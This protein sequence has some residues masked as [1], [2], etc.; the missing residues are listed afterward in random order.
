MAWA[1]LWVL[2]CR[3]EGSLKCP[4]L[5]ALPSANRTPAS[6]D[7]RG[8]AMWLPLATRRAQICLGLSCELG[9]FSHCSLGLCKDVLS[10]SVTAARLWISRGESGERHVFTELGQGWRKPRHRRQYCRREH[11]LGLLTVGVPAPLM[12]LFCPQSSYSMFWELGTKQCARLCPHTKK[13]N[14]GLCPPLKFRSRDSF[15]LRVP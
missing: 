2:C 9:P 3:G 7:V 8:R 10:S 6:Q 5:P 14:R 11:R 4:L 1:R 12:P 15:V 13:R